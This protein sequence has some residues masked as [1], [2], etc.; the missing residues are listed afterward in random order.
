MRARESHSVT[1]DE[2]GQIRA[3]FC[4]ADVDLYHEELERLERA[5]PFEADK[6]PNAP[7]TPRVPNQCHCGCRREVMELFQVAKRQK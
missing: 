7:A 3:T 1:I 5:A 2:P 6:P 4:P